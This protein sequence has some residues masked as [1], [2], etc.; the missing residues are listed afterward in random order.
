MRRRDPA[1]RHRQR[2]ERG[3]QFVG[4]LE[5]VGG[6]LGQAPHDGRLERRRE[7]GALLPHRHR[8]LGHVRGQ[9]LLRIETGK[10][11][12]PGEH[13]V[14]E[15]AEGV[16]IDPRVHL[17]I[18]R[19]LFGGHVGG[20]AECDADAGELLAPGGLGDRLRHAEIHHHCVPAR[21][22]HVLRLD[23]AMHHAGAVRHRQRLGDLGQ[24]PHRLRHRE[25]AGP[26]QAVPER[27]ALDERHHVVEEAVGV[28]GVEHAEDVGV[29]Q[30]G[31]HLDFA[32]EPVGAERGRQ[33]GAEHLDRHPAVVLQ[34]LGE[35]HRGHAALAEFPFDAI[36]SSQRGSQSVVGVSHRLV[37]WGGDPQSYGLREGGASRCGTMKPPRSTWPSGRMSPSESSPVIRPLIVCLLAGSSVLAAQSEAP[38]TV[39]EWRADLQLLA[40]EFP[41]RH[42]APFLNITRAQW[43]SAVASLDRR[44]PTL[45]QDQTLV[46]FFQL[47]ALPGDAHT[48]V[49]P[50][51]ARPL[52]YYPIEL[53]SFEDGLFI[54]R[55][56]S[57]HAAL[58]GARVVR[59]GNASADEA[60]SRVAT[61]IPHENDWWVRAW[62][63][64][65]LTAAE[66]VHGLGLTDGPGPA[67]AG[68]GA[69][70][71]SRTPSRLLPR[72]RWR[73]ARAAPWT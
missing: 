23:V 43:D 5:P 51:P 24:Q 22:E 16:D 11:R 27:L 29:L 20:R 18:G 8:C 33:F 64:F 60:M 32:G 68:R 57:A 44:L 62:G 37:E 4:G 63:P 39:A 36:A 46:A 65:W 38:P 50:N 2:L 41:A 7:S 28:A 72:A 17:R 42:P 58:V 48:T 61:I 47:V 40:K 69:R 71:A 10:G 9:R 52:H 54:R 59:F 13:L 6:P 3:H 34:V 1:A 19:G 21:E 53:Y 12:V 35:V 26:G 15:D 55:A 25:L 45:N 31:G 70:T 14:A 67:H 66:M 30:A 56:D 73:T 49:Q